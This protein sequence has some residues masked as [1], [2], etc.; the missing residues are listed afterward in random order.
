MSLSGDLDLRL[1]QRRQCTIISTSG[2]GF[3]VK[4]E[5]FSG[6]GGCVRQ[7]GKGYGGGFYVVAIS[8]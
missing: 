5:G 8:Q 3:N 2:S 1:Q 6:G 4:V 7:R